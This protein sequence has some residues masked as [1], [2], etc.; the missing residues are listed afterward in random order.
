MAPKDESLRT[1][2][3]RFV[4]DHSGRGKRG[5]EEMEYPPTPT[6]PRQMSTV[7]E[8]DIKRARRNSYFTRRRIALVVC[9]VLSLTF[10]F[11]NI[12]DAILSRSLRGSSKF[13]FVV[14]PLIIFLCSLVPVL[15][16]P[17]TEHHHTEDFVY[18][19]AHEERNHKEIVNRLLGYDHYT[20][21]KNPSHE[22][23]DAS[24]PEAALHARGYENESEEGHY[25]GH[26]EEY[27]YGQQEGHAQESQDYQHHEP[28]HHQV[29]HHEPAEDHE[30][31][32]YEQHSSQ[33]GSDEKH[34]VRDK[35]SNHI[36]QKPRA[37][38]APNAHEHDHLHMWKLYDEAPNH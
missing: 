21:K 32:Y 2:A 16:T 11:T 28:E 35:R 3:A 10:T 9:A 4:A 19:A 36:T 31:G 37:K 26:E 29:D 12:G 13:L 18:D 30:Q 15:K 38:N 7:N 23:N 20:P 6:D 14:P 24:I 25:R 27:E 17:L 8:E 34:I 1:R 5:S 22:H 33:H